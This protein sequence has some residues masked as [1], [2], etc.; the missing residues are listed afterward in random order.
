MTTAE[1][2]VLDRASRKPEGVSVGF[3]RTG[4]W[5]SLF[6]PDVL[7]SERFF[8]AFRRERGTLDR[9]RLLM[10]AVLED[11]IACYQRYLGARDARGRE[12]FEETSAWVRCTDRSALFAFESICDVLDIDPDYLRRGLREWRERR[13]AGR[14]PTGIGT[15]GEPVRVEAVRRDGSRVR[16]SHRA[17]NP[18]M[19]PAAGRGARAAGR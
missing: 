19:R 10:L 6:E 12:L 3:A 2:S 4:T 5:T 11:A 8:E 1:L 13:W 16:R 17:G 18:P 14:R 9:E 7:G 15:A